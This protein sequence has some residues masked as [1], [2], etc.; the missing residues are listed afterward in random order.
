M[1]LLVM[2]PIVLCG[3]YPLLSEKYFDVEALEHKYLQSKLTSTFTSKNG[4]KVKVLID[5]DRLT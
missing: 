2:L 1:L 5:D 4:R 3:Q